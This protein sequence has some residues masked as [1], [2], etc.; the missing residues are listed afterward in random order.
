MVGMTGDTDRLVAEIDTELK[1]RAKADP[2]TIREIVEAALQREFSTADTA[3]VERRIEE[4][5]Q[6]IRT[7]E[8]EI[9]DRERELADER[10]KLSRLQAQLKQ[11]ENGVSSELQEAR[12][13]LSDTPKDPDNPAIQQ[14]AKDLGM[15]PDELLE[16]L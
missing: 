15:T 1:G 11:Y 13:T 6:R 9:S 7:L 12:E 16:E 4:S 10:D 14:W 8:R 5:K 2:R 3:A